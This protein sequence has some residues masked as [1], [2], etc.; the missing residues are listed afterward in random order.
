MKKISESIKQQL[1]VPLGPAYTSIDGI[2][3]NYPQKKII[4]V[5]DQS[6]LAFLR[7]G[8]KPYVSVFDFKTLRKRI[9]QRDQEFLKKTFKDLKILRNLPST[10]SRRLLH[11][12]PLYVRTGGAL[13]VYGEEDLV[14][15][16]FMYFAN[17]DEIVVYGQKNKGM[18]VVEPYK[19]RKKVDD[20]MDKIIPD[21]FP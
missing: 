21:L 11:V 20:L 14:A 3:K 4:A 17:S 16:V 9:P 7:A 1:R 15:L 8:I 19:I 10:V 13:R 18:I 2:I 5:G 12:V 6:V